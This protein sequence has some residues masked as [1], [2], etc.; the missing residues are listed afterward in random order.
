MRKLRLGCL[1]VLSACVLSA[2]VPRQAVITK[3][4]VGQIPSD[5]V[6]DQVIRAPATA[7]VNQR[8]TLTVNT[9]GSSTCRTAGGANVEVV[10]LT[11]IITPFD[12]L[13]VGDVMC[14][15]DLRSHPRTVNVRFA[16]PGEALIRVIGQSFDGRQ[17]VTEQRITITQ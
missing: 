4:V 17:T 3:Q 7:P 10:G 5:R 16:E 6:P 11:A 14:T 13:P 2:C 15:D 9:Y 12:R 8:I 1:L